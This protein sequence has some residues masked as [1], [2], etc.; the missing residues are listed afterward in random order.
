MTT[1]RREA[2]EALQF[3]LDEG[4]QVLASQWAQHHG[5]TVQSAHR[6]Y[7]TMIALGI[8]T[9]K[10]IGPRLWQYTAVDMAHAQTL[11][12]EKAKGRLPVRKTGASTFPKTRWTGVSSVF[13]MGA[14]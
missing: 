11:A 10:K 4:G 6:T 7:R 1:L 9:R 2:R 13:Q 5:T 3:I 8:L 12:D 14:A